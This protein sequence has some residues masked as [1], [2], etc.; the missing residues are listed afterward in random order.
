MEET[1]ETE[2]TIIYPPLNFTHGGDQGNLLRLFGLLCGFFR[3]SRNDGLLGLLLY[4]YNISCHIPSQYCNREFT[5]EMEET[6]EMG[7]TI[8][9]SPSKNFHEGDRGDGGDLLGLLHEIC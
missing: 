7:E 6:K 8:F 1:K 2:E 4:E 5:E 9:S 3:R